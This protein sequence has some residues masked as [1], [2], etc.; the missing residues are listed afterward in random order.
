MVLGTAS[1]LGVTALV[2]LLVSAAVSGLVRFVFDDALASR[3]AA[4]DYAYER[5]KELHGLVGRFDGRL[6]EAARD[7]Y[8]RVHRIST[9]A[10]PGWLVPRPASSNWLGSKT[11]Q[12][13]GYFLGSTVY[14][15]VAL[16]RLS[17][18]F[19][20]EAI[21]FDPEI[22]DERQLQCVK[23]AKA[24][25]WTMTDVVLF[26]GHDYDNSEST[27][28]FFLDK[29]RTLCTFDLPPD[30]PLTFAYFEREIL[31]TGQVQ[32]ALDFFSCFS[33]Q[34]TPLRWDRVMTL[35]LL[36]AAFADVIGYDGT[37]KPQ[38][39]FD[40]I[41]RMFVSPVVRGTLTGW[42]RRNIGDVDPE[43]TARIVSALQRAGVAEPSPS[44]RSVT[45]A[46]RG[47]G[48]GGYAFEPTRRE[49]NGAGVLFIHGWESSQ[50]SYRPRAER[51]AEELGATCLSFDLSGHGESGGA[52]SSLT[53]NDHLADTL[54]A[55]DALARMPAVDPSRIGICGAS[56]GAYLAALA[57]AH[58]DAKAV[59]LRAPALR[60]DSALD[61]SAGCGGT[62][63]RAGDDVAPLRNLA[64]FNG[65]VLVV[66]SEHDEVIPHRVVQAYLDACPGASHAVIPGAAHAMTDPGWNEAFVELILEWAK[67][68]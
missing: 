40:R 64:S 32:E 46:A 36:L 3:K 31:P 29:L 67:A 12:P 30:E 54:A 58:R 24:F 51:V 62:E 53:P 1:S 47:L 39:E 52:A 49:A 35:Q 25:Q 66:E 4:R 9:D 28:H 41:A 10:E 16:I 43:G 17:V 20:R 55:F 50:R 57:I 23:Y 45:V 8:Q 6:L 59:L 65:P 26:E 14:R 19:D 21:Y 44:V 13:P 48:L 37:R 60:P 38:K 2:A 5:R 68:L 18:A 33:R 27:D 56:Y 22:A 34:T 42:V 7:F 15:F 11:D 61:R 63:Y